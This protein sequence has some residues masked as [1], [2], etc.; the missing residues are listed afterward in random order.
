MALS[1]G[2]ISIGNPVGLYALLALVP[3]II[4]Y[5][6]RPKPKRMNIPSLMFFYRA[7]GARKLT[8]FLKHITRDWLILIQLLALLAMALTFAEPFTVYQHDITSSHTV[9][10]IDVSASSQATE[11]GGTRFSK[12]VSE[13][14]KALGAQNTIVLAKDIPQIGLQDASSQ[15]AIKYLNSLQPKGTISK[16]GEAM[17]LAGETLSEGRVVVLSDFINTEGQ[18]P[19]IA[20]SVL[21]SKGLVVNFKNVGST[22]RKNVGIVDLD[23]GNDVSTVYVKNFDDE[24]RFVDLKIGASTTQMNILPKATE[25]F[26]FKT[27]PGVNK[28]SLNIND[29]LAVDNVAY[30]SAPAGGKPKILHV[31]NNESVFL[32][33][34][35]EASGE[36]DVTVTKPPVITEGDFD[37]IIVN[38]VD[39]EQLL[40]GTFEDILERAQEGATVVLAVQENSDAIDYKGLLPMTVTGKGEGGLIAVDQLNRFTKNIDFGRAS[41]ALTGDLIGEQTIVASVNDNPIITVKPEGAGKIVYFG[42]PE[43]SDFKFSPSYPI[44]WTELMKYVTEQQDVRNL[45]FGAGETLILDGEQTINTPTRKVKRAALVLDEVGIYELEDRII[46][47]NLLNEMESDINFEVSAGTKSLEYELHP[48]KEKREFPWSIWLLIIALTLAVFEIWFV[49]ARGDI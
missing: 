49:R 37:V 30:L 28:L 44:F 7:T 48:V 1:F 18:D 11:G 17:I 16:I 45:N 31:T 35:L 19:E 20:K 21:Q 32:K 3:L 33:N 29:D 15:E 8:S 46:A 39:M 27:P 9:I 5:L 40:P 26:T 47:V 41:S 10:V 13:A 36:L 4:L 6:I 23:A 38:N 24:A 42:I 12:E 43:S 14:K 25:T 2:P 34:A 22:T